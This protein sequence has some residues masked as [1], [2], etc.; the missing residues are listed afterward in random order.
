MT[1]KVSIIIVVKNDPGI[2]ATLDLIAQQQEVVSFETIVIDASD[3]NRL[4]DIRHDFPNVTWE[5]FDQKGKRFTIT[6]QRNRGLEL[7]RGKIIAFIDANC[8]PVK[9]WL[10]SLVAA[11]DDGEK[12]VTGPCRPSNAKNLVHYIEEHSERAYVPECTTINV[13]MVREVADALGGF[14]EHLEY[15]EDVDFFWRAVEAGYKICYDPGAAITHD[16]G[17]ASEQL[18][19]AYRYGKS[20]AILHAKHWRRRWS[21][22]LLR[23]PH[24][25]AYPLY[26]LG[27][28]LAIWW[29]EYLLLL[30]IPLIRTRSL[31]V[32]IHHFVFGFGV[33]AGTLSVLL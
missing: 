15:G 14:D 24:V 10:K 5:M 17:E 4:A 7:A 13:A 29:P 12:I 19:R 23:E 21:Q 2:R 28:P 18:R 20:R 1:P 11:I 26:M 27:L 16:Y 8:E 30:L 31:G 6:E 22:L 33:I 3:P 25:W 32:I 9:H